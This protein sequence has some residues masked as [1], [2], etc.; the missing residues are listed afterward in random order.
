MCL[1]LYGPLYDSPLYNNFLKNTYIFVFHYQHLN[2]TSFFFFRYREL[3]TRKG[4][5]EI[6]DRKAREE[7]I[8]SLR[9]MIKS[10]LDDAHPEMTEVDRVTMAD[11]MDM[12]LIEATKEHSIQNILEINSIYRLSLIEMQFIKKVRRKEIVVFYND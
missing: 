2:F 5:E 4:R 11:G 12:S 7:V 3:L 9:K 8:S 6:T 1:C 10:W